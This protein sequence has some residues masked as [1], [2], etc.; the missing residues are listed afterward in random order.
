MPDRW[1]PTQA[2]TDWGIT[3]RAVRALCERGRVP[4]ARQEIVNGRAT[5]L[6]PP[7]PHPEKQKPGKKKSA[8]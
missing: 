6:I 5:W 7:Q 1:T 8:P 4:G 2:A 3:T